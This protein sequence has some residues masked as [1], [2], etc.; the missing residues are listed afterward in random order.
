MNRLNI[1]VPIPNPAKPSSKVQMKFSKA[2]SIMLRRDRI[3][4]LSA[5]QKRFEHP[6]ELPKTVF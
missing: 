6:Q 1:Q 3:C 2:I 4:F 5:A